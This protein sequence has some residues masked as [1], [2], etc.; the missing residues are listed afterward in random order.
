MTQANTA[1]HSSPF[2]RVSCSAHKVRSQSD[3]HHIRPEADAQ[4]LY[5]YA[6]GEHYYSESQQIS[7]TNSMIFNWKRVIVK[8][9]AHDFEAMMVETADYLGL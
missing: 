7:Q 2:K 9:V 3:A 1:A 5:R 8:G 4:G 6:R